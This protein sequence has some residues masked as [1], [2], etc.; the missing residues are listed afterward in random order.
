[1]SWTFCSCSLQQKKQ[2]ETINTR[3]RSQNIELRL[4]PTQHD[5]SSQ[6]VYGWIGELNKHTP[7]QF[8]ILMLLAH[9]IISLVINDDIS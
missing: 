5:S 7:L 8:V 2:H 1:M 9:V 3:P 6:S 4:G